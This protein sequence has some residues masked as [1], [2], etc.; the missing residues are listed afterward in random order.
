MP[1]D[2]HPPAFMFYVDDFACDGKVEAMT[3]A[4]VGAYVLLLCKA[5]KESPVGSIP[6]SDRILA[7]WCRMSESEWQSCRESI[8]SPFKLGKDGRWHQKRMEE[9]FKKVKKNREVRKKAG[10]TGAE[11]RWQ[12]HSKRIA[13]ASDNQESANAE[14]MTKNSLSSSSSSINSLSP[15]ESVLQIPITLQTEA[16]DEVWQRW[17]QHLFEVHKQYSATTEQH[18]IEDLSRFDHDDAVAA[19]KYSIDKGARNL[20]KDGSHKLQFENLDR[21][22]SSSRK[23][24]FSMG[25]KEV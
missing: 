7:R 4:E 22:R 10:K 23:K 16:F 11:K 15:S 9:E 21:V 24:E 3:A 17:K 5:W 14:A 25:V 19:V 8:L 12:T 20:I 2:T 13:N 18:D 6:N 1:D